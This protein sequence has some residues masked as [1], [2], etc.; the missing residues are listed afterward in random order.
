VEFHPAAFKHGYT[1]R[2]ILHALEHVHIDYAVIDED[3]PRT[4]VFGFAPDATLLELIVL[5]TAP[6][7]LVIHCMR[8][9][10]TE[11]DKALRSRGRY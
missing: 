5:H 2:E 10:T 1:E 9:R 3:P 6:Y 11:L 8:A 4:C 7:D